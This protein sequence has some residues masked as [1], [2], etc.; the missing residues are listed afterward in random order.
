MPGEHGARRCAYTAFSA[1]SHW[2]RSLFNPSHC[3]PGVCRM[4]DGHFVG[5]KEAAMITIMRTFVTLAAVT[6]LIAVAPAAAGA[7][8]EKELELG[9]GGRFVLDT[10]NGALVITGTDRTGAR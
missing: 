10:D 4:P 1:L 8:I 6:L 2:G 5:T 9:S 3:A 7:R